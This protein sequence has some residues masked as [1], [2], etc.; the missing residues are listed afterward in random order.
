MLRF[1]RNLN[2]KLN[3]SRLCHLSL[4]RIAQI[5]LVV[6]I[7]LFFTKGMG[8]TNGFMRY[9]LLIGVNVAVIHDMREWLKKLD[10]T[11]EE[12]DKNNNG[13]NGTPRPRE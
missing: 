5:M 13:K 11:K 12:N 9:G 6:S 4:L 10:E 8:S 7:L 3:S 1:L 2:D